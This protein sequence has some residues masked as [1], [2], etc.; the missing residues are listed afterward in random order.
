MFFSL[1]DEEPNHT[2]PVFSLTVFGGVL[3][4]PLQR[5][6]IGSMLSYAVYAS[7]IYHKG[8]SC[9]MT[10]K[11]AP[12]DIKPPTVITLPADKKEK[13]HMVLLM[14]IPLHVFIYILISW[15]WF[16]W[17]ATPN[18]TPSTRKR[19]TNFVPSSS[20]AASPR[21]VSP[22]H[23]VAGSSPCLAM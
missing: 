5:G 9:C 15:S 1:T 16:L 8:H 11:V 12:F 4:L 6:L 2:Q 18:R 10:V 21:P 7:R 17:T 20:S 14:S 13:T 22:C 3:L 19:N 23:A